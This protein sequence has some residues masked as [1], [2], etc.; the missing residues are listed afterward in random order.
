M[1][2]KNHFWHNGLYSITKILISLGLGIVVYMVNP[3]QSQEQLAR[4][5]LGWD[6][7]SFSLLSFYWI[8]FFTTP[9]AHIRREAARE[10][11]SR[12]IIFAI[13][14][15][16]VFASMFA[17]IVLLMSQ[18]ISTS[19]KFIRLIV[20]TLGMIFSWSLL[21]TVFTVK[22]AHLYYGSAK[23]NGGGL[24]FPGDL[25]PDFLDFAYFS[26]VLGMTFQVSDVSITSRRIRRLVLCH[27]LI[28]F[29]YNAV[30]IAMTIN[31]VA[32]F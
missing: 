5:M 12:S 19:A 30:I 24:D 1:Q 2:T 28:S 21:H 3:L 18:H 11:N 4:I 23:G 32:G 15:V 6:V 22:Y 20:A 8:S 27:G 10:D 7:F 14:L 16:T 31:I 13:T 17:V 25:Q 29:G 9:I 26:Y